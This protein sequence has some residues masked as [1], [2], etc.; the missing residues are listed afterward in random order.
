VIDHQASR[1]SLQ[2]A[3]KTLRIIA[4]KSDW[5]RLGC[6]A[7]DGLRVRSQAPSAAGTSSRCYS[8]CERLIA[9][10]SIRCR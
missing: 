6:V 2:S 9:K 7:R 3:S 4:N 1:L 10:E 5:A 8:L